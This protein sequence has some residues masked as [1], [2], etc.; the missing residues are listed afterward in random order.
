MTKPN[1]T[2]RSI[3]QRVPP[4]CHRWHHL[5]HDCWLPLWDARHKCYLAGAAAA[6]DPYVNRFLRSNC[7]CSAIALA[8]AT[9]AFKRQL[10]LE[11]QPHHLAVGLREGFSAQCFGRVAAMHIWWLSGV[12][13]CESNVQRVYG[14]AAVVT[15]LNALCI[16]TSCVQPPRQQVR[17]ACTRLLLKAPKSHA[18]IRHACVHSSCI[19]A[20]MRVCVRE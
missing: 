16:F 17:I 15:H 14:G 1:T 5:G 12:A 18:C 2:C 11:P 7:G 4:R 19:C 3:L 6:H 13:Q 9:A 8:T 10:G 20:C